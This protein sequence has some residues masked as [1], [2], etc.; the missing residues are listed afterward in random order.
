MTIIWCQN[1]WSND[2]FYDEDLDGV[3]DQVDLCPHTP[4][5]I[6]VDENGC[7]INRRFNG[8]LT[9][10]IG[11][12]L[13]VDRSSDI[14]SLLNL[15]I[16]YL[17]K[18][19]EFSLSSSNYNNTNLNTIADTENDIFISIAHLFQTSKSTTKL[20]L[21]TKFAFLDN[22]HRDNDYYASFSI[23][24]LLDQKQ[25]IFGYYSYTISAD[26]TTIDYKNYHLISLGTGYA[27]T[28]K[29]YSSFTFNYTTAYYQG[30]DPFQTL[31]WFNAYAID[32]TFYLSLNY[33]YGLSESAY[34]HTFSFNIGAI[35]E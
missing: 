34:D 27:V 26:T 17:Y 24:Y 1:I 19:W 4:F 13:N 8:K 11:S 33:A 35:F 14:Q 5:D 9:L 6:L 28:A 25:N 31:S 18:N 12:N 21:G 20:S 23:E 16:G 22:T 32:E 3:S 29:W 10:Q 2:P 15:Y 7:D 30:G